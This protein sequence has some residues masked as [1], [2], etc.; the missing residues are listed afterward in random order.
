VINT[1]NRCVINVGSKNNSREMGCVWNVAAAM[2]QHCFPVP[3]T[4]AVAGFPEM[5]VLTETHQETANHPT[6][7]EHGI[8]KEPRL[9]TR[10][11]LS[12]LSQL[13]IQWKDA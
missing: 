13:G 6:Q 7:T 5:K 4:A 12:Q 1:A 10:V 11:S 9:P 8:H 3:N 2:T